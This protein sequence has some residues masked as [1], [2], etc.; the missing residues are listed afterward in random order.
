MG[1]THY[2][3]SDHALREMA[4]RSIPRAVVE[5]ILS[6]PEQVVAGREGRTVYQSRIDNDEGKRYLVRV[7]VDGTRI[8]AL[9]I[10]V[11]R[12]SKVQKYWRAE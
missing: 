2:E 5:A 8:T 6:A 7:V 4:R 12:T 10:T 11:Y 1:L 9:V 3:F